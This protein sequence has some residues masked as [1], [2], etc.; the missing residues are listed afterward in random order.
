MNGGILLAKTGRPTTYTPEL[1]DEIC[2]LLAEG[3]SLRS[4]CRSPLMPAASTVFLWL[5]TH[6]VFS[7]QYARA[8]EESADALAEELLHIASTPKKGKIITTKKIGEDEEVTVKVEDMLGHRRLQI[9]T[10]KFL[11]AKMKPKKYGDKLTLDGGLKNENNHRFTEMTDD[12][13]IEYIAK[14]QAVLKKSKSENDGST[15]TEE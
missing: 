7:E 3:K 11:M 8:K 10:I 2:A 15:A 12:E 13:L 6:D 4:I 9:D 5:R 1:A 14:Q